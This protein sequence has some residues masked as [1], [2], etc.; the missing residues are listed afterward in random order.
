MINNIIGKRLLVMDRTALAACAV[1]RAKELGLYV[2]VANFYKTKDSPSKQVADE[3]IDID[4]SNI[5]AMLELIEEKKIDGIF[6]GWTDSH[7]P[8]YAEI[9]RR[10]GL[11]CCG[12]TEQFD[13]LSNDKRKFKECCKKYGVPVPKDY[14]LSMEFRLEDLATIDY[15]V[16]VKPADESGSRGIRKCANESELRENYTWL[17]NR[18]KSKKIFVEQYIESTQEVFIHYTMQDGNYSLSS[19]FMKHRAQIENGVAASA[20]LHVFPISCIDLYRETVEP[21]ILEMMKGLE[22]KYGAINFQG[23]I[24]DD[25]FYFYESGLRMGGEQHYVFSNALNG[26]NMLDLMIEFSVTGKM[27]CG[28]VMTQ[29]NPKYRKSCV[30]YYVILRPGTITEIHGIEEVEKMTQVLQNATFKSIGTTIYPSNSLDR[31]IYRLH[32]MDDT[33]EMLARTLEKI[34][35][36]LRIL[37]EDGNDMQLEQLTYERALEMLLNS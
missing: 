9:C 36:T 26:I 22:L 10:A 7:L 29:D 18:S 14:K 1:K 20:I 19:A 3:A 32:V 21:S 8:F 31:V 30:N 37:D 27:T 11:P 6:V 24:I 13:T 17:Y 23:S 5:D 25:K 35:H 4:I 12:T 2:I 33:P 28:D 15:P 16:I 34:S